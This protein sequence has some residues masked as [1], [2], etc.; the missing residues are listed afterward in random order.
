[1]L[2]IIIIVGTILLYLFVFSI[3]C[4]LGSAKFFHSIIPIM[5]MIS[6]TRMIADNVFDGFSSGLDK[7]VI[8]IIVIIATTIICN[9]LYRYEHTLAAASIT[10][11]IALP[12]VLIMFFNF[13]PEGTIITELILPLLVLFGIALLTFYVYPTTMERE[14]H[15]LDPNGKPQLDAYGN[16]VTNE[17]KKGGVIP[18]FVAAAYLAADVYIMLTIIENNLFKNILPAIDYTPLNNVLTVGTAIAVIVLLYVLP[19]E[20][21]GS[22]KAQKAYWKMFGKKQEQNIGSD[23]EHEKIGEDS[24]SQNGSD[25]TIKPDDQPTNET[26]YFKNCK[27]KEDLDRA[28]KRLSQVYHPDSPTGDEETFKTINAQHEKKMAELAQEENHD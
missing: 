18:T 8:Y 1:M 6:L 27:T 28:Y 9:K 19:E 24:T 23:D 11:A 12:S 22:S 7:V 26:D 14:K 4:N 16:P 25:D 3:T 13:I 5:G 20:E 15:P 2:N 10:S 21:M 17:L